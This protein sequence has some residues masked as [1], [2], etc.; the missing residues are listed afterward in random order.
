MP[1]YLYK[2][3]HASFSWIAINTYFFLWGHLVYYH[4]W[5]D[6][7]CVLCLNCHILFYV[8]DYFFN[9][10]FAFV[11]N[12]VFFF[13]GKNSVFSNINSSRTI[14]KYF[15]FLT[16]CALK[17]RFLCLRFWVTGAVIVAIPTLDSREA[18]YSGPFC[19]EK[20]RTGVE[21]EIRQS[22][23]YIFSN[24]KCLCRP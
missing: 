23:L 15:M 22:F 20:Q 6:F 14:C 5:Y 4:T 18:P 2:L 9:F 17:S 16:L 19:E 21:G 8:L 10:T 1:L 13:C 7:E 24:F 12:A 3:C 11:F